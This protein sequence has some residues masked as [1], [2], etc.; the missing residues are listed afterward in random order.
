MVKYSCLHAYAKTAWAR[1]AKPDAFPPPSLKLPIVELSHVRIY[2]TREPHYS[3]IV[4][5]SHAASFLKLWASSRENMILLH[6]NTI[7]G[8]AQ[9]GQR[10]L[11]RTKAK[12][13]TCNVSRT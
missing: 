6:A 11:Q 10:L 7:G 1:F 13:D 9:A 3:Q 8:S 12:L 4:R 5:C 2:A